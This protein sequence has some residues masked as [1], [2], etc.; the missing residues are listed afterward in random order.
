VNISACNF[1]IVFLIAVLPAGT[2]YFSAELVLGTW[3]FVKKGSLMGLKRKRRK[4]R[5]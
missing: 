1:F 2:T 5:K 4:P 3:D